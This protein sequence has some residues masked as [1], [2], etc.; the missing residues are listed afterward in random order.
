MKMN[1]MADD[2]TVLDTEDSYE[3]VIEKEKKAGETKWSFHIAG[4]KFHQMNSVILDVAEGN[5]LALVPEPTNRF[6]PN[7]VRII[8]ARADKE[9]MLGYVPKKFSAEVSAAI[10]I[11]TK[12]E[13]EVM[14]FKRQA[15][16]WE[17]C[18]VEI[19]EVG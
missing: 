3:E 8:Y 10:T 14:E 6:D 12:L 11:G 7:A 16:T 1:N 18:L 2:V 15:K 4:V 19:R 17:M 5:I 13:C 9:A